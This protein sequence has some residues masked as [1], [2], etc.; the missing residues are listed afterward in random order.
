[1]KIYFA[2]FVIKLLYGGCEASY[3]RF[4]CYFLILLCSSSIAE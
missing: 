2:V 3:S 4:W 1:M